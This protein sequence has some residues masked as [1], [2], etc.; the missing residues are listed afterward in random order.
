M[1]GIGYLPKRIEKRIPRRRSKGK[2][3]SFVSDLLLKQDFW[4]WVLR[5][6][7]GSI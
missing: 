6:V 1:K 4:I 7:Q 2:E 5:N 3:K